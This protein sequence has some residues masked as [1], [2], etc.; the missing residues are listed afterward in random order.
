MGET[1]SQR[2]RR[3]REALEW[4]NA[5]VQ[6]SSFARHLSPDARIVASNPALRFDS[7]ADAEA[8]RWRRATKIFGAETAQSLRID[9]LLAGQPLYE[10]ESAAGVE[11]RAA[12]VSDEIPWAAAE[13]SPLPR[14]ASRHA[15]EQAPFP[16]PA[17][18]PLEAANAPLPPAVAP[19]M[20][21]PSGPQPRSMNSSIDWQRVNRANMTPLL[22]ATATP[23]GPPAGFRGWL[24][25]RADRLGVSLSAGIGIL[26]V[27]VSCVAVVLFA[28]L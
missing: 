6:L 19:A 2:E 22:D 1:H 24:Q 13:Q 9:L 10:R 28:V 3:R 5:E 27:T 11:E 7:E 4:W 23:P 21:A 15:A 20:P 18:R 25:I 17:A 12:Q 14:P 8:D 26:A 16:G